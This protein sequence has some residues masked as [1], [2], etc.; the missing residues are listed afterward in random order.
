[1]L[2]FSKIQHKMWPVYS[3]VGITLALWLGSK[4]YYGDVFAD[5]YKYPAKAASL[6]ATVLMCWG[7]IL[8]ARFRPLERFF[9]GLDKVY[10][11]HKRIGRWAFF[12]IL[13]HP[14][15]LSA[16]NL[17]DLSTFFLEMAFRRPLGSRYLWGQNLGVAAFLLMAV[18]MILTLW[19][20]LP[21]H[22]WKKS[23]EGF[24]LVLFLVAAH[25]LVVD[26]DVAAYPILAI[27]VY[28]FLIL[29]LA[30]IV[31]MRFL[32]RFWG[33]GFDYTVSA[34][35]MHVDVLHLTLRPSKAAMDFRPSQFVYL[36]VHKEGVTPEPHPYS[37][38]CGYNQELQIKLGIKVVGDHTRTLVRLKAGDCVTLYGPYG[39]FSDRFLSAERD[40]VFIAGGIG[41][42]PF[43]GM[44][45]VALHSE[46]RLADR[47]VPERLRRLHPEII[48]TW[49]SPRVHLFYVCR[50]WEDAS[51]DEDIRREAAS[52]HDHGFRALEERGHH[53][54]LYL[55]SKQ[56]RITA[57]Y[58]DEHVREGV[59]NKTI[60]L[61][62]PSPMV[63]SL[64]GQLRA[65]GLEDRR[66][67]V[68]DFNLV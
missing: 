7:A 11:V 39:H 62:G 26:R 53:Y 30:C 60:F 31:Y 38:A 29:A 51:F 40:C 63:A 9:G 56:G 3:T 17:P 24:G 57:D 66:I 28:G 10:Q 48:K 43:L 18:L 64:V 41:I 37:I 58:V 20:K 35:S 45:H 34:L 13:F 6:S 36:V 42:T 68:E 61:C 12:I 22:R 32:Y 44:W 19:V 8:S 14:L 1:M 49:K 33:P 52:S 5:P 16:H 2:T 15:F 23:H 21:Y 59:L 27:W 25:I 67:V 55:T 4:G 65:L 47:E 50:T 54:E 46:E